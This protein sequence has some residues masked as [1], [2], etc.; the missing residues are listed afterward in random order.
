MG[1]NLEKHKVFVPSL[2]MEMVPY[3][4]V[5]KVLEDIQKTQLEQFDKVFQ[6]LT[7][8]I[9]DLKDGKEIS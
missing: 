1:D 9:E 5:V 4:V 6:E 8:A 7:R 2:G 3:T